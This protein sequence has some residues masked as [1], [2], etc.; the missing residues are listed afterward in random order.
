MAGSF[1]SGEIWNHLLSSVTV[2]ANL[3]VPDAY[4]W[5]GPTLA[6]GRLIA[7]VRADSDMK[8]DDIVPVIRAEHVVASAIG[9]F[10]LRGNKVEFFLLGLPQVELFLFPNT[11]GRM[12]WHCEIVMRHY[13]PP[14]ASASRWSAPSCS[15][16]GASCA[17]RVAFL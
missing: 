12:A 3:A 13:A 11:I 16:P 4:Q 2:W 14:S 7:L 5:A 8:A 17:S 15:W 1:H 10:D 6:K 9:A